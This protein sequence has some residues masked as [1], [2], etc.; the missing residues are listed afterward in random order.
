MLL[1]I[2]FLFWDQGSSV[3]PPVSTPSAVGGGRSSLSDRARARHFRERREERK[4]NVQDDRDLLEIAL[5]ISN[6]YPE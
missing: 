2:Y 3:I 5:M 1:D 4:K 6:R